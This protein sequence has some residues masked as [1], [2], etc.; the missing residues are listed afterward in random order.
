MALA[1]FQTPGT[2]QCSGGL[3]SLVFYSLEDPVRCSSKRMRIP[4]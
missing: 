4:R 2:F 1:G 3:F